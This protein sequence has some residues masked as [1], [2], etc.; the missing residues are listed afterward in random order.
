[1]L[2]LLD[3]L[4]PNGP[5]M[6]YCLQ[7]DRQFMIVLKDGSLP[8]VWEE[9]EALAPW[10]PETACSLLGATVGRISAGSTASSTNTAT[11]GD[12]APEGAC[13]GVRGELGGGGRR[14]AGILAVT[15]GSGPGVPQQCIKTGQRFARLM[16]LWPGSGG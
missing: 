14:Q 4:Y 3:G 10:S 5:V 6:Q 13:G 11:G 1:M 9:F 15:T 12:G 8:S 16:P 2:I 7:N